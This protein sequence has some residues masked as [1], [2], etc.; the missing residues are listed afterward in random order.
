MRY[1]LPYY[2][3]P[4]DAGRYDSMRV[5]VN[6]RRF[7]RDST[8][9]LAVGYDRGVL[10]E[11]AEPDG[12]WERAEGGSVLEVRVPWALLGVTDPSSRSVLQGPGDNTSRAERGPDG[13]WHLKPGVRSWPDSLTGELGSVQVEDIG[14]VAGVHRSDGAWQGGDSATA[15]RFTWPT[16]N[17]PEWVERRRPVED[18]LRRT[19]ASLDP[20]GVATTDT[21]AR[22]AGIPKP[23]APR[24]DS[25]DLAWRAGD[26]NRALALYEARLKTDPTNGTA[27]HRVAL[28]HAW[29]EDYDGALE[30]LGRLIEL[31]PNNLDAQVDHARVRAWS[32]D[33]SGALDELDA[34]LAHHP[35]EPGALEA[36]ALFE[37]W[38]G[39]YEASLSGYDQLLAIAPDN[40]AARREQAQVLSWASRY[41]ASRAAYDSLLAENPGDVDARLGLAR[42]LSFA[43][44]LDGAIAQYRK[45][46][47]DHRGQADAVRGLGRVLGWKGDLVEAERVLRRAV[48]ADP[49]DVATL[50]VLAQNLQ[51]QGR[52]AAAL[53]VLEDARRLAPNDG[54]VREQLRAVRTVLAP[55][56]RPRIV[57]EDDSE[58]NHMATRTLVGEWHPRPRLDLQADVYQRGLEQN[59]LRRSV[60]GLTVTGRWVFEP[61]WTVTGDLGGSHGDGA[62]RSSFTSLGMGL[63]TPGR[64][65]WA[66]T[67]TYQSH[68][69]DATAL[70]VERGVRMGQLDLH[71]RWT[72]APGWRVDASVGRAVLHG[73]ERNQR[74]SG[75]LSASKRLTHG[76]TVG[77]GAR[78]FGYQ[79]D[80]VDGYFDPEFYGIA[81]LTGRWLYEPGHWSLLLESAPGMQKVSNTG[82]PKGAWRVSARAAYRF[83]PGREVSLSGGY[84]STGLQSFST[85]ASDYH[86]T[87]VILGASWVF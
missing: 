62:A 17:E 51:W 66:G 20:Y 1:N 59:A 50:V 21:I 47:D 74:G 28:I 86:Y 72:P 58:G 70:Q 10:P 18:S 3:V 49:R 26:Q 77:V 85:G 53:D 87:A 15:G 39:N 14:L 13:R 11:G 16:W 61:G 78:A 35:D 2:T 12:F 29:N 41:N 43:N 19:F 37:A 25:A 23:A 42:V 36:R 65:P 73:T 54:D 55:Q 32:G 38:A 40:A 46:L 82:S 57:V 67:I 84:S 24:V 5:V 30:L 7:S 60:W 68:A 8:E 31:Q 9:Y 79:K 76:F 27:L 80:L 22:R 44:D 34:L 4:N 45:V 33:I 81:E 63:S 64:Y 52:N 48:A 83:A 69:L 75:S 71:G 6:R 56:T